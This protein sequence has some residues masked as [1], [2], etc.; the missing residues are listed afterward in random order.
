MISFPG[1]MISHHDFDLLVT[2]N[3]QLFKVWAAA[4]GDGAEGLA[5]ARQA[6]PHRTTSSALFVQLL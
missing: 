1:G 5:Y 4:I 6:L 2:E 3:V